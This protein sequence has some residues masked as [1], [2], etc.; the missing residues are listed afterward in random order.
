MHTSSQISLLAHID[1]ILILKFYSI[2]FLT[3]CNMA[4]LNWLKIFFLCVSL[5]I[6]VF[7]TFLL[8]L[9]LFFLQKYQNVLNINFILINE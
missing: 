6:M 1:L 2:G 3:T 4:I 5:F 7:Y 8:N 9:N